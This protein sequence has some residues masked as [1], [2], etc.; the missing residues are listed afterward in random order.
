ME[1][2][3]FVGFR[4]LRFYLV[5]FESH[6][7][8]KEFFKVRRIRDENSPTFLSLSMAYTAKWS[9]LH[10]EKRGRAEIFASL[11]PI[12]KITT[13]ETIG[14]SKRYVDYFDVLIVDCFMRSLPNATSPYQIKKLVETITF[15]F[16]RKS[17]FSVRPMPD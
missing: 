16:R 17:L 15:R 12:R 4:P 11:N 14:N 5:A 7:N 1:L 8:A 10:P 9:G 2:D 6:P 13:C 3:G